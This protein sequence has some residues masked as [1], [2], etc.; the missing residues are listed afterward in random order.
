MRCKRL[1]RYKLYGGGGSPYSHKMR[2]ILHYR[3]LPFD[4]IQITPAVRGQIK[5]DGPPVIPIL[6]LPEDDSLHVDS[7]PLAMM[8]E[9]RHSERS[10]ADRPAVEFL[11]LSRTT[12]EWATKIMF[13]TD[14]TLRLIK[15][16]A[17]DNHQRQ[18][19][20]VEGNLE[21]GAST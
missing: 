19:A 20:W 7:T 2:A 8:L 13:H 15:I 18:Y 16:T 5:H 21:G 14:G 9:E 12:T 4:W 11:S 6:R 3:R 1:S 10:P 17:A